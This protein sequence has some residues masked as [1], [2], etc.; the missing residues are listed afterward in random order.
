M[1]SGEAQRPRT[2]YRYNRNTLFAVYPIPCQVDAPPTPPHPTS[3]PS[4]GVT[5]FTLEEEAYVEIMGGKGTPAEEALAHFKRM[6]A[7]LGG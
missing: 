4:H 3:V 5:Q 6:R 1:S 2:Y 7:C